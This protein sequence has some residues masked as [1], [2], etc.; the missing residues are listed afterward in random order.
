MDNQSFQEM[1]LEELAMV[2]GAAWL[3]AD[4]RMTETW[5]NGTFVQ[6]LQTNNFTAMVSSVGNVG[7]ISDFVAVNIP[8]GF[9]GAFQLHAPGIDF[10]F[11]GR[12]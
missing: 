10:S 12:V 4:F 1:S 2:E 9:A 11:A 7:S 8:Q 6:T 3:A 5:S